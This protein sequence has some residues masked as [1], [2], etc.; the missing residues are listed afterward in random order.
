MS[1]KTGNLSFEAPISELLDEDETIETKS[2]TIS[3]VLTR[4]NV[5][6]YGFEDMAL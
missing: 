6:S 4:K 1:V 3:A 2:K 5:R